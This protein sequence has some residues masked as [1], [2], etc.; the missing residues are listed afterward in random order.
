MTP[1]Y[2]S[3]RIRRLTATESVAFTH[4]VSLVCFV[5]C[6]A[7]FDLFIVLILTSLAHLLADNIAA[8]WRGGALH[9][10]QW[11]IVLRREDQILLEDFD[12]KGAT[13]VFKDHTITRSRKIC[14]SS[15]SWRH[16]GILITPNLWRTGYN[17][18][19]LGLQLRNVNITGFDTDWYS[20]KSSE[21][22]GYYSTSDVYDGHFDY[23]SSAQDVSIVDS[24]GTIIDGCRFA[25]ELG[26]SDI[27]INDLDGGLDLSG[28]SARGALVSNFPHVTDIFGSD[29][30]SS[31]G[32]CMAYCPGLCLRTFTLRVEQFGTE[33]WKLKVSCL[34]TILLI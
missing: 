34:F 1:I 9:D 23:V 26:V 5:L 16:E 17:D 32:N 18:P 8:Q 21:P 20:C 10:N 27:V 15:S 25:S 19:K 24:R 13:Q 3:L 22:I 33:N 28:A 11:G 6:Q 29:A 7:S 30:C 2:Q 12:I 14:S 4:T 31:I